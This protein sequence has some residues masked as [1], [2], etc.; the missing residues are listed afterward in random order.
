V[1]ASPKL[2]APRPLATPGHAHGQGDLEISGLV[3]HEHDLRAYKVS[4]EPA[5]VLQK[6]YPVA[7]AL[8]CPIPL[9]QGEPARMQRT[10]NRN[11]CRHSCTSTFPAQRRYHRTCHLPRCLVPT[12]ITTLAAPA[13]PV[14]TLFC[15]DAR[16]TRVNQIHCIRVFTMLISHTDLCLWRGY[17][18]SIPCR[19][20]HKR[21]HVVKVMRKPF[22]GVRVSLANLVRL[23]PTVLSSAS[24]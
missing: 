6:R 9:L 2:P 23:T 13:N 7:Q 3:V 10:P 22:S 17:R 18:G 24:D 12:G 19:Q 21:T 11:P 15:I 20:S 16:R 4:Q 14:E 5:L 8:Y 1:C